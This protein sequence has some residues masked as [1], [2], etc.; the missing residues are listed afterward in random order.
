MNIH[1]IHGRLTRDPELTRGSDETHDRVN[2]TVAVDR[3]FGDEA[4]FFDCVV[5]GKRARVIDK[6]FSKGQE[7][8]VK[9]EGQL[10]KYETRDGQKRVSY[11]IVVA[12]FDF[13]GNKGGSTQRSNAE[14]TLAEAKRLLNVEDNLEAQESDIPF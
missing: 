1:I 5:F 4:D 6:W 3:R 8:L 10:R 11:N 9:G 12:D 7:I 14:E 2:F 13:C